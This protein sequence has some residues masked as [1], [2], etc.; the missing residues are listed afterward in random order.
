M[1]SFPD[2][3]IFFFYSTSVFLFPS[4]FPSL[5]FFLLVGL[6]LPSPYLCCPHNPARHPFPV[7]SACVFTVGCALQSNRSSVEDEVSSLSC[8]THT[9][10]GESI[11]NSLSLCVCFLSFN[12][13]E[14]Q[15]PELDNFLAV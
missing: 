12:A 3:S 8:I 13:A 2:L 9:V 7:T 15:Q 14:P 1:F 6:I 5:S 10:G 11:S 4:L